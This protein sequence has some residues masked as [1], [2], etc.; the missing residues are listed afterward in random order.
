[1]KHKLL[2]I[3]CLFISIVLYCQPRDNELSTEDYKQIKFERVLFEDIKMTYG[4]IKQME[5]LFGKTQ[6]EIKGIEI[7]EEHREFKYENGLQI[8]FNEFGYKNSKIEPYYIK[9]NSIIV[10]N[11]ELK[12]GDSI[13]V[14]GDDIIFN[15]C[16]DGTL[17]IDF[18]HLNGD[19][20]PIIIRFDQQTKKV[21]SIEYF[22]W[23]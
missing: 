13:E 11:I 18:I 12:I 21:T 6:V 20:C 8:N 1:M 14:F 16:N 3:I 4:D 9:S 2:F 22:V 17:S 23:T 7:G 10:K 15:K 19:C 5:K